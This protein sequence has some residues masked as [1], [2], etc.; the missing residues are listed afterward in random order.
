MLSK[1]QLDAK[2][3]T[4]MNTFFCLFLTNRK[5]LM[6]IGTESRNIVYDSY[7][8]NMNISLPNDTFQ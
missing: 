8:Y 3:L 5:E 1:I 2:L 4:R 6:I 7:S